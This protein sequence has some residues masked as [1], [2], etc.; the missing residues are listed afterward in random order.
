MKDNR[1]TAKTLSALTMLVIGSAAVGGAVASPISG[2]QLEPAIE[3][4]TSLTVV[5]DLSMDEFEKVATDNRL[6]A[7][8][9]GGHHDDSFGSHHH[10]EAAIEKQTAMSADRFNV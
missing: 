2:A 9:A 1:S 4:A 7:L 6:E 3:S 5:N 8:V 10:H